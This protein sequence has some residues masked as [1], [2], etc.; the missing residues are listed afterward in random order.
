MVVISSKFPLVC[1]DGVYFF[2]ISNNSVSIHSILSQLMR[3]FINHSICQL[4]MPVLICSTLKFSHTFYLKTAQYIKQYFL[5]I[6]IL[7]KW[8]Q[9]CISQIKQRVFGSISIN[10]D[11]DESVS[12]H[13][14]IES[15][16]LR[17]AGGQESQCFYM[18]TNVGGKPIYLSI[19]KIGRAI[20]LKLPSYLFLLR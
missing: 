5:F 8:N 19:A 15:F 9:I 13:Q 18:L 10:V 20:A 11:L 14:K 6:E 1:E 2:L 7:R 12:T 3:Y 4:D 16:L 17:N